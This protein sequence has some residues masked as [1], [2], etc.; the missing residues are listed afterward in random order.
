MLN[1]FVKKQ[2]PVK[3]Q[4]RSLISLRSIQ[5]DSDV[6]VIVC[7]GAAKGRTNTDLKMPIMLL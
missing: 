1:P 7:V 3:E 6:Q 2:S 5:D 4:P